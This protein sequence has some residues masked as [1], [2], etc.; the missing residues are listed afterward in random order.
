MSRYP[1][2]PHM[3]NSNSPWSYTNFQGMRYAMMLTWARPEWF[4]LPERVIL[5]TLYS[6][7]VKDSDVID[8]R[9]TQQRLADRC[10]VSLRTIKA[11]YKTFLDHGLIEP[12]DETVQEV[13]H[14]GP[15]FVDT[16]QAL[17]PSFSWA[18]TAPADG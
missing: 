18:G 16:T 17:S 11:A 9:V 14:M 8:Q 6:A 7:L 12:M 2:V 3:N 15:H 4:T 1:K 10:G 5:M 13:H